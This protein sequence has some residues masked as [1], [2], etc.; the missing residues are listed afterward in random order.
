MLFDYHDC[1]IITTHLC[2][3]LIPTSCPLKLEQV[4]IYKSLLINASFMLEFKWFSCFNSDMESIGLPH[5]ALEV[6][7]LKLPGWNFFSV[8]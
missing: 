6:S 5:Q 3:G 8:H 4:Q 7:L 2:C 1:L